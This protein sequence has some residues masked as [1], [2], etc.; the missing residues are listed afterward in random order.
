MKKT[1]LLCALIGLTLSSH[2]IR[3]QSNV[4]TS[5][6]KSGSMLNHI[7]IYVYNLKESA[8]FY[9]NVVGVKSIPEPFKD[10]LHA[11]FSIGPNIALHVI[12]GAAKETQ[13]DKHEH[14]CFSVP[15][16]DSFID[17]LAKNNVPYSNMAGTPQ[18][19]TVRP[20]GVKQLY[21]QD[22]DGHWIEINNDR[23]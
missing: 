20:D 21:F 14:L 5:P 15:S 11:W 1:L 16:M 3:A 8:A 19:L 17:K 9:E 6:Q 7:A 12:Q 4:S 13:H 22:P 18:T 2:S 10:G 23:Q